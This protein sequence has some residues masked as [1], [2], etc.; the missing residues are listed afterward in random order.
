MPKS[1]NQKLKIFYVL[2]CFLEKSDENH[3]ISSED[4]IKY[5]IK[6][7]IE[8]EN[9]SIYRDI[10]L[11]RNELGIDIDGRRG[12]KYRLMS[13]DFDFSDLR[14]I[15]ECVRYA[16]FISTAKSKE[17]IKTLSK[18][19]NKYQRKQLET[20]TYLYDRAKTT[21]NGVIKAIDD[22]NAAMSKEQ[23]GKPQKI[24]FK[25]LKYAINNVHTR[26][27]RKK[28]ST[29]IVSPYKLLINDGNYYL[30]AFADKEQDFRTYRI[31]RMKDL[32]ILDEPRDGEDVF[33]EIDFNTYNQRVFGM[34]GGTKETVTMRFVNLLLDTAV[35]R[36]GVG[37]N[38]VYKPDDKDH[39]KVVADVEVSPQFFGWICGFGNRVVIESPQNVVEQF[40]EHLR[41]I[42]NKYPDNQ[43]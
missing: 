36:F 27:E 16:K 9:R 25:Y 37:A 35:D 4:I 19:C 22:I 41:K 43:K 1:E 13:R 5:L 6:F 23:G 39:F 40:N 24:S 15:V 33:A 21:Q 7:N 34:H 10:N 26:V 28:G 38:V 17:L 18:L 20:D 11:L 32:K 42:Q 2:K 12:T 29:Y 14:I 30:L 8:A 3:P 31:D